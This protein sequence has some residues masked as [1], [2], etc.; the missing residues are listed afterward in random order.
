MNSYVLSANTFIVL[1]KFICVIFAKWLKKI[2]ISNIVIPNLMI[3][4]VDEEKFEDD[5]AEFI[6]ALKSFLDN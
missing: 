5:Y 1:F 4:D 3:R 6:N 2:N